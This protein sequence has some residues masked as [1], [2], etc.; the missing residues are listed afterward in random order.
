MRRW[1][2]RK[3]SLHRRMMRSKLLFKRSMRGVKNWLPSF[4][5]PSTFLTFNLSSTTKVLSFFA[6]GRWSIIIKQWNFSTLTLRPST[7]GFLLMKPKSKK[8]L[9]LLLPLKLLE[10]TMRRMLDEQIRAM[11][12]RLSLHH[13]RLSILLSLSLSLSL[14]WECWLPFVLKIL[15]FFFKKNNYFEWS[16]SFYQSLFWMQL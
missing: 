16:F 4:W 6:D 2:L 13:R 14:S 5:S 12:T 11:K 10:G 7:L 8:K 9:L 1:R 3:Y 15:Y